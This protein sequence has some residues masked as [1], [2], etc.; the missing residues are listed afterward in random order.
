MPVLSTL[1]RSV[2]AVV[3][4]IK[5]SSM[6][7]STLICVSLS[8]SWILSLNPDPPPPPVLLI[9]I[10]SVAALVV[11][12]IFVPATSVSVSVGASATMSL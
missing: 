5:S 4:L 1:I 6:F 3:N 8:A 7:V 9:V 11:I 2:P 12:V 10:S